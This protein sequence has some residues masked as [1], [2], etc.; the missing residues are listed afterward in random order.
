M[1][2]AIDRQGQEEPLQQRGEG[3]LRATVCGK[4]QALRPCGKVSVHAV[5]GGGWKAGRMG[6]WW[7]G[8]RVVSMQAE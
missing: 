2:A 6:G 8:E 7:V 3:V 1:P 4:V 5:T